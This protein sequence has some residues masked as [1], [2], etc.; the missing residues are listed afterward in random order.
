MSKPLEWLTID[1]VHVETKRAGEIVT[2]CL[3][4]GALFSTIFG[5]AVVGAYLSAYALPFI[6]V[7]ASFS[8]AI[9][10]FG[11]LFF[12][13]T[14]LFTIYCFIPLLAPHLL[15]PAAKSTLP[16]LMGRPAPTKPRNSDFGFFMLEY[17]I[18]YIPVYAITLAALG[19]YLLALDIN[20]E[21]LRFNLIFPGSFVAGIVALAI[22]NRTRQSAQLEIIFSY[23]WINVPSILWVLLLYAKLGNFILPDVK[24]PTYTRQEI[25]ISVV[26]TLIPLAAHFLLTWLRLG[27]RIIFIAPVLFMCAVGLTVGFPAFGGF[28]LREAGAGGGTPLD[29][30]TS[31]TGDKLQHGCLVLA[32]S[33]YFFIEPSKPSAPCANLVRTGFPSEKQPLRHV[34]IFARDHLSFP[35]IDFP[36]G[37]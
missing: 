20:S 11:V 26:V 6:L 13:W 8:F 2:G 34:D 17:L 1:R 21:N 32:T 36:P 28:V 3:I 4:V 23:I 19:A 18:F 16:H 10:V 7:D 25:F 9:Q 15:S 12:Y 30:I 31:Q 29:F 5:L 33:L 22:L 27:T 24:A 35:L 37:T 14:I